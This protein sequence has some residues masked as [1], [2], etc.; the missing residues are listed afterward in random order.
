LKKQSAPQSDFLRPAYLV[1]TPESLFSTYDEPII[2]QPSAG[3]REI[4]TIPEG[5]INIRQRPSQ[6]A[7]PS[8]QNLS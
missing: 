4:S 7:C 5:N 3:S 8:S 6:P 2:K 1:V